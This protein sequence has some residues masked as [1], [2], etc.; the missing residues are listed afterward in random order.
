MLLDWT[1]RSQMTAFYAAGFGEN[2]CEDDMRVRQGQSD[3]V[4]YC[5]MSQFDMGDN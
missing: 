1:N 5:D 3:D 2:E 4:T